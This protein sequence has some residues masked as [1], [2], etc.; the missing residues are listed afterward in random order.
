MIKSNFLASIQ[1]IIDKLDTN[2]LKNVLL[3]II[4][5]NDNLKNFF[6]SMKEA[7]IVFDDDFNIYF[8]NKMAVKILEIK[9]KIMPLTKLDD[10]IKDEYFLNLIK[11]SIENKEKLDNFEYHLDF[12]SKI[13]ISVSLH[14]FVQKGKI[15]GNI[16]VIEDISENIENKNRL[17]Q[18]E[19]LA[20]LTTISAGIAHEIKNPL[21][22]ISLH[23]Q[24]METELKKDKNLSENINYSLNIVKEEINR[25]NNIIDD[26]L[27]TVRPL[28]SQLILVD[29]NKFLDSFIDFIKPE[30]SSF[31]IKIIK[32]YKELPEV[33]LDEKYF[34]QAL[35]NLIKNSV[36]AIKVN[37][38]ITV[39]SYKKN[40]YVF[41]NIIDNGQGI[42]VEDQ[43]K[44]FDPYFTTKSTGTGLGLTIVYK[45]IKDHKGIITF[46][47]NNGETVFSI[48]L[49]LSF[50]KEGLIEYS[51]ESN[52][53]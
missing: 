9:N 36:Q 4:E 8:F 46:S 44:I 20:A 40:N 13:Y 29:L 49:P 37:G 14:P 38:E 22:A 17:R 30:L 15:T 33:W 21:G 32:D 2:T 42:P 18:A 16:L 6:N 19:S 41:I 7:V 12:S 23:I 25:L 26:Y 35:L 45:I 50:I 24:L 1:K 48:R 3:E 43:S 10:I 51:G 27:M 52:G 5:E 34:R 11:K 47:S 39:K 31:N 28:N 53:Q